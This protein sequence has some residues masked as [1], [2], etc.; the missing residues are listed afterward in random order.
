[1]KLPDTVRNKFIQDV[2]EQIT[3]AKNALQKIAELADGKDGNVIF[4]ALSK[5]DD[6]DIIIRCA[7]INK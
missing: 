5:K 3:I 7:K 4:L 2:E 1:M 6:L